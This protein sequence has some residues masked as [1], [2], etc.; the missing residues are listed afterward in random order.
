ML[1]YLISL[2]RLPILVNYYFHVSFHLKV[3]FYVAKIT[4]NIIVTD[5][6]YLKFFNKYHGTFF[7]R[8]FDLQASADYI[9]A[10]YVRTRKAFVSSKLNHSAVNIIALE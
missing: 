3:T 7:C 8:T 4:Q 9:K 5:L 6:C 10:K 1:H 2:K